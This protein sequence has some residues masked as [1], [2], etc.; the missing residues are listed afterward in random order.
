MQR[1]SKSAAAVLLSAV[2]LSASTALAQTTA[3]ASNLEQP[4]A[5]FD[6]SPHD[7][8]Q[9]FTVWGYLPWYSGIGIGVGAR[10]TI[11]LLKDGFID[12]VNDSVELEFGADGAF[13]SYYYGSGFNIGVPIGARWTFH[14]FPN[15]DAYAKIG[16]G[17]DYTFYSYGA[18]YANLLGT[19]SAF[20]V[21][22]DVGSGI[23]Y[24][25]SGNLWLRAEAS[26]G[27]LKVG[28]GF[29]L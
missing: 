24:K 23:L 18:A 16:I 5:L 11:P 28:V 4:N 10:Y 8:K 25:L 19:V 13:Y 7:R 22:P 20:G 12:T 26:Y 27:G 3:G 2:L 9:M 1:L 6:R 14:I 21:Y 17:F 15:F 29:D